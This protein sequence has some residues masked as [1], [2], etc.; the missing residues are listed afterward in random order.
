VDGAG[1]D[2]AGLDCAGLDCDAVVPPPVLEAQPAIS[3][4]PAA[5][6][7]SARRQ[8]MV[9]CHPSSTIRERPLARAQTG[10][11]RSRVRLPS[12][13][14]WAARQLRAATQLRAAR[15]R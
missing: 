11:G 3:S 5:I 1:V 9:D 2:C 7:T 8:A 13:Q 4:P 14:L 6:T 10:R 15:Q 12:E